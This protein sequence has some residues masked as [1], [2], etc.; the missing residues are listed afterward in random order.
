MRRVNGGLSFDPYRSGKQN[1]KYSLR[2][3]KMT[4][5]CRRK[6]KKIEDDDEPSPGIIE[7]DRN[8]VIKGL[9][10]MEVR[11]REG[12]AERVPIASQEKVEFRLVQ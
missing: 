8:N 5:N 12:S 11:V 3:V 7:N 2:T 1:V 4:K 9:I 10:G 6:D